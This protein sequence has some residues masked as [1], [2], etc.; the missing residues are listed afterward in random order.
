MSA[1]QPVG[2]VTFVF[3]DI[4]GSTRLLETLGTEAYR[5]AFEEHRTVVRRA[6]AAREGYEVDNEGDGFFYAFSSAQ[7]AAS[8]VREAMCALEAGPIRI[9]VAIHTGEPALDPPKYVGIDVHRAARIMGAAH[10]GQVLLSPSTVS[11]LKPMSFR[12]RDLGEHRLKDLSAP[13]RLFQLGETQFPPLRT[14]HW[15]NLPVPA[16]PFVGREKELAALSGLLIE[17]DARLV[18]LTGPGGTGKTR[19]A[20]QAAAEAS[21]DFPDGVFWIPLAPFRDPARVLPAVAEAL[22]VAQ[23][24]AGVPLD[25]LAR[26]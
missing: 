19:L 12:L 11:L 14:L 26:E 4:A 20:L 22:S 17:A 8:A 9:R 18:S 7:A 25:D 15:T 2:T 21:D 5:A 10:G 13:E 3:T 16:T 23:D 6:F 1:V 24:P